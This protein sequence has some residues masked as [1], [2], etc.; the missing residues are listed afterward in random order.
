[1]KY[2]T[3]SLLLVQ[4]LISLAAVNLCSAQGSVTGFV[5]YNDN[6]QPVTSGTGK[7]L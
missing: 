5:M 1:M 7:S 6:Y 4:I 3:K 2:F